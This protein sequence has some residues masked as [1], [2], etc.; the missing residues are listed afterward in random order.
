DI[1]MLH[2]RCRVCKYVLKDYGGKKDQ[3]H[4]LGPVVSDVW[5][6]I[7]RIKH[8]NRR[9][10][11]PCQLPIHLLE[12]L[13]LMSSDEGDIVFDPFIGTGTSAIAAKKLGRRYIG[14]DIGSEYVEI[15]RKNLERVDQSKINDC[16][17]S[18]FLENI[19]TIRNKDWETIKDR[20]FIPEN[21]FELQKVPIKLKHGNA[22]PTYRKI[23]QSVLSSASSLWEVP[24]Q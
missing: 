6:D 5:T 12:R 15:A 24:V 1:R 16:Y 19:T 22:K 11:H 13:L 20:F 3:M 18:I 21:H 14:I 8:K 10:E 9:D 7:H 23:A 17:V 4:Q 2:K